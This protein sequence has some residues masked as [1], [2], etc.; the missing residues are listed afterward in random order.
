[1][2]L[3][4]EYY[5]LMALAERARADLTSSFPSAR[6]IADQ[7]HFSERHVKRM[8]SALVIKGWL[9]RLIQHDSQH[10]GLAPSFNQFCIPAGA[11]KPWAV[12]WSGPLTKPTKSSRG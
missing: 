8:M 6:V 4:S 5:V 9:A 10:G 12:A 2:L 7:E 3:P 11:I 1:M